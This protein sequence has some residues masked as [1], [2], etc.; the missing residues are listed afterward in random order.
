MESPDF[1]IPSSSS[2]MREHDFSMHVIRRAP[3]ALEI[4]WAN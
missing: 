1:S 2:P 4:D 3:S